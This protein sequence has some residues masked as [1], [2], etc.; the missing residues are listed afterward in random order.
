[1]AWDIY[2]GIFLLATPEEAVVGR[3][4]KLICS[5]SPTEGHSEF[6]PS[7]PMWLD[8]YGLALNLHIGIK[9]YWISYWMLATGG[10]GKVT[11]CN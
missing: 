8:M 4:K 9:L 3:G 2:Q 1:M 10:E 6:V 11:L 7:C 5:A